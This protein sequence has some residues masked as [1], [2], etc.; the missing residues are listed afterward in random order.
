MS[1]SR[2]LGRRVARRVHNSSHALFFR[3]CGG[4]CD[5]F[6]YCGS[7]QP[8]RRYCG[9][10]CSAAALIASQRRARRKHN[11]RDTEEGRE[12]HRAEEAERRARRARERV[13]DNSCAAKTG[14]VQEPASTTQ[15][16]TAEANDDVLIPLDS[17]SVLD[18]AE[19]IGLEREPPVR[20]VEW[21]L[22]AWPEL[23]VAAHRRQDTRS[24]CPF[25]GRQGRIVRVVS[26]DHWRQRLRHGFE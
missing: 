6:D 9:D 17:L 20:A 4:C 5:P 19:R 25:C 16:V 21:V 1:S 3:P 14:G 18:T 8:G 11:A 7:C 2:L 10:V 12:V 22:V 24:T 23:S 13:G 26:L 15:D